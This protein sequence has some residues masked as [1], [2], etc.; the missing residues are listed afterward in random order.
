MCK[1]RKLLSSKEGSGTLYLG[2]AVLG[3]AF[4]SVVFCVSL[5]QLYTYDMRAQLIC[6]S[7]ADAAAV[8]GQ[9][10]EGFDDSISK[11]TAKDV[12]NRNIVSLKSGTRTQYTINIQDEKLYNGVKT[13]YKIITVHVS[14]NSNAL[15]AK[16]FKNSER[17][18]S[19]ATAVVRAKIVT[20][21]VHWMNWTGYNMTISQFYRKAND[22]GYPILDSR[23]PIYL[24]YIINSILHPSKNQTYDLLSPTGY[25]PIE[26]A[27]FI[28]DY[29]S[30][31]KVVD[32]E[33]GMPEKIVPEFVL[34][35]YGAYAVWR[36]SF[37]PVE[38]QAAANEG[39]PVI[40]YIYN[41]EDDAYASYMVIPCQGIMPNGCIAVAYTNYTGRSNYDELQWSDLD[42]G[43]NLVYAFIYH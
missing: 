32:F 41:A 6:D 39:K 25:E 35:N 29:L 1:V 36:R 40:V 16:L 11:Q 43:H 22:E 7:I 23:S 34:D 18:D 13:G 21:E 12:Y 5:Y 15:M 10:P 4:A 8:A 28:N 2:L 19:K 27:Y 14:I 17:L 37:D 20:S 38:L 42:N 26:E 33:K 24:K 31:L 3:L 9:T 30:F